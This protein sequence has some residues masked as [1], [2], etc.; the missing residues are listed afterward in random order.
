[1]NAFEGRGKQ[2]KA[3]KD[4]DV[5]GKKD[6]VRGIHGEALKGEGEQGS[7]GG[8]PA[9]GAEQH[10]V[11]LYCMIIRKHK[12]YLKKNHTKVLYHLFL[13]FTVFT[14]KEYGKSQ[15]FTMGAC[16]KSFVEVH[17]VRV[18]QGTSRDGN[19]AGLQHDGN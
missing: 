18:I 1:M 15:F 10:S 11:L 9:Y 2:R 4:K 16:Q 6:A 19:L 12:S 13:F 8:K 5:N 17:I 7:N 3:K 14:K